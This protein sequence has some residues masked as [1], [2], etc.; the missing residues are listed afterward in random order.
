MTRQ[1]VDRDK[2]RREREDIAVIT[3]M[4]MIPLKHGQMLL[5]GPQCV[6]RLAGRIKFDGKL[7]DK[8]I[9]EIHEWRGEAGNDDGSG[10]VAPD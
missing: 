6:A 1:R 10:A 3:A 7:P 5:F 2:I 4:G 9:F 8:H